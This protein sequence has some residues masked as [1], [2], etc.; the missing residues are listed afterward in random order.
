M[1][2]LPHC[3]VGQI[4]AYRY[5]PAATGALAVGVSRYAHAERG[6]P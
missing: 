1:N 2:S 5:F 6:D 4:D 3:I